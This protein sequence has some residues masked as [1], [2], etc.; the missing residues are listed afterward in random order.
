MIDGTLH[1]HAFKNPLQHLIVQHYGKKHKLYYL[2][3][4]INVD[5]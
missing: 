1:Y 3:A 5:P 2:D 4:N